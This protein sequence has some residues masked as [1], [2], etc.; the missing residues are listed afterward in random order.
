MLLS[1]CCCLC[2]RVCVYCW[3][4]ALSCSN[5]R[6]PAKIFVSEDKERVLARENEHSCN[7]LTDERLN[8]HLLICG[9]KRKADSNCDAPPIKIVRRELREQAL[10]HLDDDDLARVGLSCFSIHSKC[11]VTFLFGLS[12]NFKRN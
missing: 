12:N 2:W 4:R 11:L 3:F 6:C 7:K 10:P 1:V 9:V 5:H 8:R